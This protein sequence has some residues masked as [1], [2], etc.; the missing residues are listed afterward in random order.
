MFGPQRGPYNSTRHRRL[1]HHFDEVIDGRTYHIEVARI[2]R[3]RWRAH[4]ISATGVR[5]A[6]MPFYGPTP[7][8][9]ARSLSDWL[10]LAHRTARA[11]PAN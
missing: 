10:A 7:I 9:A 2:A 5:A 1:V 6:L 11:G 3:D 4:I 8:E